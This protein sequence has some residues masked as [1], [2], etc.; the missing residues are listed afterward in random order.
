MIESQ[1]FKAYKE[2]SIFTTPEDVET[3]RQ[4]ILNPHIFTL[5]FLKANGLDPVEIHSKLAGKTFQELKILLNRLVTARWPQAYKFVGLVNMHGVNFVVRDN[6][7][8]LLAKNGY[9]LEEF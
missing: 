8:S 1:L 7:I 6:S 9:G 4:R 5:P 2:D 3:I